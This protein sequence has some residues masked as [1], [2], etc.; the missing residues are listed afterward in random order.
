MT[1]GRHGLTALGAHLIKLAITAAILIMGYDFVAG[2]S[3]L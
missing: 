3:L 2:R 1:S